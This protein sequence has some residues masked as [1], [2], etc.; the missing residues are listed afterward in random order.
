MA[1]RNEERTKSDDSWS[2][3][4]HP[5]NHPGAKGTT[6]NTSKS[7]VKNPKKIK[8]MQEHQDR[9]PNDGASKVHFQKVMAKHG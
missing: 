5:R 6:S 8:R 2:R 7:A 1:S 9:H 4:I 3:S